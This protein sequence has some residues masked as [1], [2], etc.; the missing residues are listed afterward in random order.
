MG[1][2]KPFLASSIIYSQIFFVPVV[3]WS[4]R[5]GFL[6]THRGAL[7]Y[8]WLSESMFCGWMMMI[9]NYSA[10]LLILKILT[11]I[12]I[13]YFLKF[14]SVM[15]SSVLFIGIF[16]SFQSASM[17]YGSSQTRGWIRP[18][19]GNIVV[20]SHMWLLSTWHVASLKMP[21][22]IKYLPDCKEVVQKK[23]SLKYLYW[24]HVEI[25]LF[26]THWVKYIKNYFT[27]FNFL[28]WLL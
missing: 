22:Y 21:M 3:C 18:T 15:F 7:I 17:A 23:N 14:P 16:F 25:L 1:K 6:D 19:A 4:I 5:T 2:V 9:E 12:F 8:G 10:I 11:F 28:I 26:Q 20:I 27:F 13:F 24:S